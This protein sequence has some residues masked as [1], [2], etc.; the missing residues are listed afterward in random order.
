[1]PPY[2]DVQTLTGQS[3]WPRP[4]METVRVGSPQTVPSGLRTLVDGYRYIHYS[5]PTEAQIVIFGFNFNFTNNLNNGIT[6]APLVRLQLG[7]IE[8]GSTW[9]PF[10]STEITAIIGVYT[11]V[12]PVLLMP[13]PY[14]MNAGHRIQIR[15]QNLSGTNISNTQFTMVGVRFDNAEEYARVDLEQE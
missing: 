11:Q 13:E 8:E 10:F 7:D 5:S 9:N 6:N 1:M 15:I 3:T 2:P 14:I 4:W 12:E